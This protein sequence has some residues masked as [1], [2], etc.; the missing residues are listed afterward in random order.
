MHTSV[1]FQID[2]RG[3]TASAG[4]EAY[5]D[6]LIRLVLG[7]HPGERVNRPDFGGGVRQVVFNANS[8]ELAAALKFNL[9]ANLQRWLGDLIDVLEL[10]VLPD[11]ATCRIH[12]KYRCRVRAEVRETKFEV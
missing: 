7:T 5:R 12:L 10:E 2:G 4:D 6:Q 9:Q 3:R 1:P 11:D 8:V